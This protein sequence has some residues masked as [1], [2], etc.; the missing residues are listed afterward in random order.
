MNKQPRTMIFA[1]SVF[2]LGLLGVSLWA[3]QPQPAPAAAG[4]GAQ[5]SEKVQ[6]RNEEY[7]TPEKRAGIAARLDSPDR[8]RD[9]KPEA[10]VAALRLRPGQRVADIGTGTGM[11]LPYLSRAVSP[12]GLVFAEDIFP[13]FLERARNKAEQLKLENIVFLLGG[14]KNPRLPPGEMDLAVM[15]D[16]YHH[17]EYPRVMLDMI[18]ASLR[19]DGRI[20]IVDYYKRG[21]ME[22]HVRLDRD[23]VA[24]EVEGFGWKLDSTPEAVSTQYILIFKRRPQ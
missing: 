9:L 12:G 21:R 2:C 18:R 15:M 4:A 6:V 22:D 5:A 1:T 14:E 10:L 16:S 17:F 3:Q 19:P 8:E 13:D 20:A 23:A 7:N 11:L 24:K